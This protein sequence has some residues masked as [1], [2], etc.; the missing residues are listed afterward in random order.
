MIEDGTLNAVVFW[1]DLHLDEEETI[2][3]AP[4]G[5]LCGG[6][7]EKHA[8][9]TF[10]EAMAHLPTASGVDNVTGLEGVLGAMA[11]VWFLI[12]ISFHYWHRQ[13]LHRGFT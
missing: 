12:V 11:L 10:L 5:F 2:T 1:F 4:P 13:C 8:M 6:E 9:S 3:S 7:L